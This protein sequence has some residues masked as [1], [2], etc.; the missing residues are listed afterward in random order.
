[1]RILFFGTY[2][3]GRH[4]RVAVLRE[5]LAAAGDDVLECNVPL[6]LDTAARVGLLRQPWRL[7]AAAARLAA[8]WTRLRRRARLLPPPDAV[9][10]GYLGHLDVHLARRTFRRTPIVLDHLVSLADTAAD[11]GL[12]DTPLARTF[13]RVDRAALTAADVVCVDTEEHV[14]L[15]PPDLRARAVVVPVG[16]SE[17]WFRR[18]ERRESVLLRVVFFGLYTPLQGT[19]TIGE[20]LAELEGA[21]DVTVTMVGRGQDFEAARAAAAPNRRVAW[22][23]WVPA[24]ELPDVV[25]GHDVCLGIFGTTPKAARVVPNK[26]FQGAAAGCALVTADTPPQR[27]ALGGAAQ[28]VPAGDP[29]ALAEAIRA[30]AADREL[31]WGLRQSAFGRA[32]AAFRP[33][34]VVRPLRARLTAQ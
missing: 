29:H 8:A 30:L 2:D 1:M 33:A 22:R 3:A 34:N 28:Y 14:G 16:A 15:L 6:A 32:D 4:P 10:V 26:V 11:R 7:P 23:D 13:A 31:L 12:A 5:G 25:A 21:E 20:A 27:K 19:V 18:P 9:V 24:G 17:R